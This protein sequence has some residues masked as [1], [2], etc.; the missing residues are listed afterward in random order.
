M[1]MDINRLSTWLGV[2]WTENS[3]ASAYFCH[4]ACVVGRVLHGDLP[5]SFV[6]PEIPHHLLGVAE[7]WEGYDIIRFRQAA[8]PLV[9]R[10]DHLHSLGSALSLMGL[11]PF[12]PQLEDIQKRGKLPILVGGTFY[13]LESLLWPSFIGY[14]LPRDKSGMTS[15]RTVREL[16]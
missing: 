14:T 2:F 4:F 9:C 6:F 1:M 12:D 16:K 15:S 11:L 5:L 3:R 13:W 8:V 10:S 7:P